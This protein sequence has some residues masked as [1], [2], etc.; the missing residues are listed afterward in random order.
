MKPQN[1]AK[2]ISLFLLICCDIIVSNVFIPSIA[3]TLP[4][5]F[6]HPKQHTDIFDLVSGIQKEA[7]KEEK[8]EKERRR[9]LKERKQIKKRQKGKELD[10]EQEDKDEEVLPSRRFSDLEFHIMK[11]KGHQML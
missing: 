4:S 9:A 6:F 3:L 1:E 11:N 10:P 8:L 7:I 2:R 5:C